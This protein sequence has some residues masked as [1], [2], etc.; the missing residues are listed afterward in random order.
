MT[1]VNIPKITGLSD[2]LY[3]EEDVDVARKDEKTNIN[4]MCEGENFKDE[5]SP[6]GRLL[7]HYSVCKRVRPKSPCHTCNFDTRKGKSR[8]FTKDSD[9]AVIKNL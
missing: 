2:R 9:A 3:I 8:N 5:V 1:C 6:V 4:K 7:Y